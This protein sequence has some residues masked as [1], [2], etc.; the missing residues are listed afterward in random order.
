MT[1]S[2]L[3]QL[4]ASYLREGLRPELP[5]WNS[6]WTAV[7]EQSDAWLLVSIERW[8]ASG[9]LRLTVEFGVVAKRLV[10]PRL[11]R[12]TPHRRDEHFTLR[13][14]AFLGGPD[15]WWTTSIESSPG[16]IAETAASIT[17]A[18]RGSLPRAIEYASEARLVSLWTEA[19]ERLT[20]PEEGW[21]DRLLELRTV[22]PAGPGT[23]GR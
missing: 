17:G 22:E 21:L 20:L 23:P 9:E 18:I 7:V 1:K 14:G 3:L 11:G 2:E 8:W 16:E 6:T 5:H 4:L 15:R 12:F 13:I 19:R 10:R